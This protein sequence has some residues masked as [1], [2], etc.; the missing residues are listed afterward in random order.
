[1][2]PLRR[3][4]RKPVY[5]RRE[6]EPMIVSASTSQSLAAALATALDEPLAPVAAERF[7]DGEFRASVPE[8]GAPGTASAGAAAGGTAD[9]R[10]TEGGAI[11]DGALAG[12]RAVVV[13]ATTTAEAH[14]EAL[15]L[16]DAAREAGASEVLTVFP[17]F[18]YARQDRAFEPGQPVSARAMAR[19]LSTGTDRAILVTP[20]EPAVAEFFEVSCAVV[21]AAPRLA[22]ALP[23][24]DDPLFLAPD[25]GARGLADTV[26]AAHGAGA[27]DH[28]EKTRRSGSEVDLV[29]H[30]VGVEGRDAVLVDDIV[31]TGGT[32][33]EA[34]RV[35]DDRGAASV[36]AAC[37]HPVLAGAART[38]LAAAGVEAVYATDTVERVESVVSAA[39]VVADALRDE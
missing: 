22:A 37:V 24:L 11:D 18:G 15:Q 25:S 34:A 38:R 16:Q 26:R 36:R 8:F 3:E 13:C 28:F 30:E 17:Y 19:A 4:N 10:S 7:P 20:H 6:S 23:A 1:V 21:D 32:M 33:A 2:D 12:R 27:V 31:A 14:V 5:L 29:P 9:R 35:L 39:P